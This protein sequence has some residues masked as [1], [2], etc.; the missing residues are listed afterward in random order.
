MGKLLSSLLGGVWGYVASA[1]VA[2]SLA[3]SA[4]YYVKNAAD[5]NTILSLKL[6]AKTLQ[7]SDVSS[8]LAKLTDFINRAHVASADYQAS[9]TIIAQRFAAISEGLKN[10]TH[11]PL[12]VDCKPDAGRM[13]ALSAAVTAANASNSPASP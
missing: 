10:A 8:Q 4:T 11:T 9:L 2:G 1:V 13:R 6:A 12:P 5:Q 7:V 3:A